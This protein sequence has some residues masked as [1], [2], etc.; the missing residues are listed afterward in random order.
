MLRAEIKQLRDEAIEKRDRLKTLRAAISEGVKAKQL[1]GLLK[2]VD[3][4]LSLK[5]GDAEL[6]TLRE[7]LQARE[8]KNAA[9]VVNVI[10]KAQGLRKEC[11]FKAASNALGKIPVE[12]MT[13]EASD[14][15]EDC[16]SLAGQRETA[17]RSLKSAMD[18]EEYESG[19]AKTKEYR[20]SLENSS[21]DDA[22]FSRA[23]AACTERATGSGRDCR[24]SP[25]SDNQTELRGRRR[26]GR[27]P[28][29]RS[30]SGD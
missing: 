5:S 24:A 4:C 20:D 14:L 8:E 23:F 16:D 27:D 7:K 10:E 18:S 2:K 30:R 19:L 15:L 3:E 9:Q 17:M 28:A 13:Q 26:D 21:L 1:H 25:G 29:D 11:R 12:L 6:E 22:E